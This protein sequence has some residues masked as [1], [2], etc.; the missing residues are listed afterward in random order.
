MNALKRNLNT[1]IQI[2]HYCEDIAEAIV[3]FGNSYKR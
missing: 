1:I 3:R 2:V